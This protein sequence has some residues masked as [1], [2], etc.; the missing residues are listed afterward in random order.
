MSR[1]KNHALCAK[2]QMLY[3]C[4][5]NTLRKITV[6]HSVTSVKSTNTL[7]CF[8]GQLG[9]YVYTSV[10]LACGDQC[11]QMIILCYLIKLVPT[12]K[13][14]SKAWLHLDIHYVLTW[15]FVKSETNFQMLN[16]ISNYIF[17]F[18]V[19]DNCV[20]IL[21]NLQGIGWGQFTPLKCCFH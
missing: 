11:T 14:N 9:F 20:L 2:C 5:V 13:S 6:S 10:L 16:A 12:T 21:L 4:L 1:T 3:A 19:W 17:L 18:W 7:C 15:T 8:H